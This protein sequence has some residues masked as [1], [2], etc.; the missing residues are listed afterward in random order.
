MKLRL[1][2]IV[3]LG[4][5]YNMNAQVGIGTPMPNQSTQL[6]VV[7][8]DRGVMIPRV[9]L[10]DTLDQTTIVNGNEESLLV[11]N[12][13]DN[14]LIKPGY[15]YWFD[16]SWKRIISGGDDEI[17]FQETLTS[18]VYNSTDNTLVYT[19]ENTSDSVIDLKDIFDQLETVTTLVDNTDGTYTYTSE[20]GT[21]TIVD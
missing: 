8:S 21:E 2:I 4:L 3:F 13:S 20:D 11:F 18:L 1:L 12:V 7:A 10:T 16:G 19:D 17:D 9:A 5:T 6:D 14:T 15:Y